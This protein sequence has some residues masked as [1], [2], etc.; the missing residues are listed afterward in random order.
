MK[1]FIVMLCLLVVTL[2]L[3]P[4]IALREQVA[5]ARGNAQVATFK[6]VPSVFE[7]KVSGTKRFDVILTNLSD[8]PAQ[9]DMGDGQVISLLRYESIKHSYWANLDGS[10]TRL[11][12]QRLNPLGSTANMR[13]CEGIV[14]R[15]EPYKKGNG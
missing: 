14:V 10:I 2:G 7:Y 13:F 4:A 3:I 11:Y 8:Q 5:E 12:I 9:F 1:A 6:V 15:I